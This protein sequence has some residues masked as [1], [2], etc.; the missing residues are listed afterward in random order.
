MVLVVD[1]TFCLT[2][3]TQWHRT[4]NNSSGMLQIIARVRMFHVHRKTF[5]VRNSKLT[6]LTVHCTSVP[7]TQEIHVVMSR[8]PN[9]IRTDQTTLPTDYNEVRLK[10]ITDIADEEVS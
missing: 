6:W 1:K 9:H 2:P 3:C 10:E 4:S 7:I 5:I 8:G